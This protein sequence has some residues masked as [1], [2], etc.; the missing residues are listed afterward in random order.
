MRSEE[1]PR[2]HRD[3]QS[4]SDGVLFGRLGVAP[5]DPTSFHLASGGDYIGGA[6]SGSGSGR[7]R[8]HFTVDG[9]RVSIAPG[10][11]VRV[12]LEITMGDATAGDLPYLPCRE[13]PVSVEVRLCGCVSC[14]V[15]YLCTRYY[16][17]CPNR[18]G[19][20][21]YLHYTAV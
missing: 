18:L 9:G 1:R 20:P 19:R 14:C 12:P 5:V 16:Y 15:H 11:T 6:S 13:L 17:L 4:L 10:Q 7:E 8:R 21:S 3:G 2:G